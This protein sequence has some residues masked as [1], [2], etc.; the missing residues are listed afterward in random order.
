MPDVSNP[1]DFKNYRSDLAQKLTQT[2]K[3]N[4]TGT[5]SR[6]ELLEES[7]ETK[8]YQTALLEHFVSKIEER[9]MIDNITQEEAIKLIK[10]SYIK[11]KER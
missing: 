11:I 5:K 9:T 2:P 6:K 3:N 4:K 7:R 10:E 8:E 1:N